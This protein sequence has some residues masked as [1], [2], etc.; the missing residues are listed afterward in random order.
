MFIKELPAKKYYS[1]PREKRPSFKHSVENI[2][3]EEI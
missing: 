1:T 2:N 3:K